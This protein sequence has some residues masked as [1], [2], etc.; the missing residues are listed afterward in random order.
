ML[1]KLRLLKNRLFNHRSFPKNEISFVV[2]GNCQS[3]IIADLLL[4]K[5]SR[6]RI[7]KVIVAHLYKNHNDG[8]YEVLNDADYIITQNISKQF[9][10]I[11]TDTILNRYGY[12]TVRVPNLFYLGY[13][14]DWC[15]LPIVEGSRCQSLL[16]DYHNKTILNTY[17]EG[18]SEEE[19]LRRYNSIK[20]NEEQ[21]LHVAEDSFVEFK[22]RESKCDIKMSDVIKDALNSNSV[23]FHSF[24][25][26]N[27]WLLN[28][29][30]NRIIRFLGLENHNTETN[31]ECLDNIK[32]RVNP[33]VNIKSSDLNCASNKVLDDRFFI[34]ECFKVYKDNNKFIEAYISRELVKSKGKG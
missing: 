28:V 24:N 20:Y 21:Y 32:L 23:L 5:N 4:E 33:I 27:K 7:T 34:S 16:G 11:D 6:F 25:H 22:E 14:P 30:V 10:G 29:Q 13:H 17:T 15:Y 8:I 3:R 31:G 18:Q 9:V 26:P 19:A 2:I 12:K 1:K